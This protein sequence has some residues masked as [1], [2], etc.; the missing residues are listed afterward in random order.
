MPKSHGP[1][2]Y[3]P[4][5]ARSEAHK[6]L[7]TIHEPGTVVEL[8]ALEY[9]PR[10][11]YAGTG[12]GYFT[13]WTALVNT[14]L[15]ATRV[16]KGLYVTLNAVK[17]ELLARRANSFDF[18]RKSD[19]LT[20]DAEVVR[21]RW[22]MVDMDPDRVSGIASTDPE[23]DAA[24]AMAAEVR[25]CLAQDGWPSP[26]FN[27][28]GN[29]A[30]LFYRIDL[31]AED[32]GLVERVL[33]GL[34]LRFSTSVVHID[35]G[36]YNAARIARLPGSTNKKGSNVPDRPHRACRILELPDELA[37][38]PEELLRAVTTPVERLTTSAAGAPTKG[39][40]SLDQ[41]M[42]NHLPEALGPTPWNGGRKWVLPACPWN[43]E[44]TNRSAFVVGLPSGAIGAGCHHNS[45]Q[46]RGWHELRDLLEP[47]WRDR[48]QP[49]S[50]TLP[51]SMDKDAKDESGGAGEEKGHARLPEPWIPF[52]ADLLPAP[53]RE[54]VTAGAK[55]IGCDPAFIALPSLAAS[56]S[57]IGNAYRIEVKPT[58]QEPSIIWASVVAESGTLKSPALDLVLAPVIALQKAADH[59]HREAMREYET[60]LLKYDVDLKQWKGKLKGAG[61]PP[62]KPEPPIHERL[63]ISDPTAEAAAVIMKENP[64][65]G[66]LARDELG[67]WIGSFDSYKNAQADAAFWLQA[68]RGAYHVVD[69]KTGIRNIVIPR[70]TMSICGC[71]QPGALSRALGA[72]HFENGLAAR[73][74]FAAPP[75]MKKRWSEADVAA[76]VIH[77]YT[78][79]A[80]RLAGLEMDSDTFGDPLPKICRLSADARVRFLA[81]YEEFAA[82]QHAA[83]GDVASVLSKLEG[84]VLRLAL[85]F[86]LVEWAGSPDQG[87]APDVVE[88][89]DIERAIGIVNWFAREI[90]RV[91]V[92]LRESE[93]AR[94]LRQRIDF[95]TSL[96]GGA[97]VREIQR[98][99]TAIFGRTA[100][101]VER[102]LNGLAKRGLGDWEPVES[103]PHGGA[104]TRRF[105]LRE[106]DA[107][108]TTPENPEDF[109]DVSGSEET[110]DENT[111]P[112]EG[113]LDPDEEVTWTL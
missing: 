31:P 113:G 9:S 23:H 34:A 54:L 64:R 93:D 40:F 112:A 43:P 17:P 53:L 41:W 25:E 99:G 101:A 36:V 39:S 63:V 76:E 50:R 82:R 60:A 86:R 88:V 48:K 46:G 67:G 4:E 91:Y 26:I 18:A 95:L 89:E 15:A 98:S 108:D 45:C 58:W 90:P 87:P 33:K 21:R 102:T 78:V 69:R 7:E 66:L 110:E 72:E 111:A 104:P 6:F 35:E 14:A 83:T 47:G 68:H 85:V 97:T 55:A 52:P 49:E 75:R 3:S 92:I 79:C 19:P 74:L 96:G 37:I 11:G 27:D 13:D 107:P 2:S 56:A 5:A 100:E 38:V 106:A 8:R 42:A 44:H 28:T 73:F 71:F 103:G 16:S 77:Q 61:E 62:P 109:E 29:G 81:F 105:V 65:G 12:S 20:T 57:L 94:L 70:T 32:D 10:G 84:L 59:L 24:L 1:A 22:L 80:N 30:T 51:N